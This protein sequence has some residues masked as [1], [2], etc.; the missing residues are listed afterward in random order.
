ML[1]QLK[2]YKFPLILFFIAI[3]LPLI[4][5]EF[6]Y[7]DD[8]GVFHEPGYYSVIL[9]EITFLVAVSWA[10]FI[11]FKT[12]WSTRKKRQDNRFE[13]TILLEKMHSY[14]LAYSKCPEPSKIKS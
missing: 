8:K 4:G 6:V 11:F 7:T 9:A 2:K 1:N 5:T 3:I 13:V 12:L 10:V 14:N